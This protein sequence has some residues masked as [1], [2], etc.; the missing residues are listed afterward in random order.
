MGLD[1]ERIRLLF[2]SVIVGDPGILAC[3]GA[4]N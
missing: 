4:Q 3:V 2:I 1:V